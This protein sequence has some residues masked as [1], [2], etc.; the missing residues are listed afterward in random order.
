QTVLIERQQLRTVIELGKCVVEPVRESRIDRL[1]GLTYFPAARGGAPTPRLIRERHSKTLIE[2]SSQQGRFAVARVT[3]GRDP[4]A[5]DILIRN[6]VIQSALHPPR[7]GGNGPPIVRPQL[8][9][10]GSHKE[11]VDS[12]REIVYVGIDIAVV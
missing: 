9:L 8:L 2:C 5:V 7:P 10:S 3:D 12:V 6:Q 4:L 11:R 1:N